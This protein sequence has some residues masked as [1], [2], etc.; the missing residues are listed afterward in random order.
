MDAPSIISSYQSKHW[1][2]RGEFWDLLL[3]NIFVIGSWL[4]LSRFIGL[5]LFISICPLVLTLAGA[6]FIAVF[7]V[8]HNFAEAYAHKTENWDFVRGAI[9]GSSYLELPVLLRWFTADIGYHNIHHLSERIPN[10]HLAACHQQNRHLLSRV[11]VIHISDMLSCAQYILW[12]ADTNTLTTMPTKYQV[13]LMSE[14][15]VRSAID[16]TGGGTMPSY[17]LKTGSEVTSNATSDTKTHQLEQYLHRPGRI[18]TAAHPFVKQAAGQAD[19][20]HPQR[21]PPLGLQIAR[22]GGLS[23]P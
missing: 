15:R 14:E 17:A 6:I 12:D 16:L 20:S 4:I 8:Q 10:Y 22:W 13:S 3:N 11:K 23:R 1:Q 2:T 7:F 21:C 5:K 9:E 18:P 19:R